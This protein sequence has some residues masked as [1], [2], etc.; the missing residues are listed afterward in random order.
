M[1]EKNCNQFSLTDQLCWKMC[2]KR[3]WRA[4]ET[5]KIRVREKETSG[6]KIKLHFLSNITCWKNLHYT[7]NIFRV[8]YNNLSRNRDGSRHCSVE[9]AVCTPGH[10]SWS[11]QSSSQTSQDHYPHPPW[12]RKPSYLFHAVDIHTQHL[13]LIIFGK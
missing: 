1:S 5:G 7:T 11:Y 2:R 6:G 9:A 10:C 4:K 12:L 13:Y 8:E 3:N